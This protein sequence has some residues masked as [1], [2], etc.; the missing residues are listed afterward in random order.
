MKIIEVRTE[1]ELASLRTTWQELLSRSASDTIFLTWEWVSTWWSAYGIPGEF[2]VMLAV[3]DRNVTR[4]IAPLRRHEVSRYGRKFRVLSF[5]GDG[6]CDSDYLDFIIGLGDE[7]EVMNAFCKAFEAE[8]ERGT[9]LELN[10]IPEASSNLPILEV[11]GRRREMLW[12]EVDVPC[13]TVALP[14]NWEDFLKKLAPRFR[15][16]VRSVFRNLNGRAEVRFGFCQDPAEL[17]QLLPSLFEL[18]RLRWAKESQP[19]VFQ[20]DRKR[21]FYQKLSPLLLEGGHLFFSWLQWKGRTLACQYGFTYRNRYFHLQEGYDPA[22]EHWNVGIGLR[23][24][25]FQELF[26]RGITEY[27]FLAGVGR[28][29]SDWGAET[30][31]S[32]RVVLGHRQASHALF[33]RGPEWERQARE[34]LRQWI[35]SRLVAARQARYEERRRAAFQDQSAVLSGN[36][37]WMRSALASCY[38]RSPLPLLLPRFRNRYILRVSPNGKLPAIRFEKRRQPSVRILYYHRVNDEAD[39]FGGAIST[40]IFEDQM[41][42]VARHYRVVSLAEATRRLSDGA[43]AEPVVAI[44]F[45]DGY[46]DNYLNAFPILKRYGLLATIFLT[47]GSIDSRD[48]LWF[49]KLAL[50]VKK[51][52]RQFIDLEVDLPRRIWMRNETERLNAKSQLNAILRNLSDAER[53]RLLEEILRELDVPDDREDTML[54]WDQIRFMKQHRIDFGGHT[55]THPFVSRLG[56]EQALFEVSECKRRIEEELQAPVE[57]FAYP[58]GREGDFEAWNKEVLKK[59][60]YHSAVSTLW[61]VNYPSTDPMELRRGQPWEE[62]LAVFAAK[63]D[64]YQWRDV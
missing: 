31:L 16:K 32:K 60:G 19:G 26:K 14:A 57:H 11:L 2:N 20:W 23:A 1:A 22:C 21:L 30:K 41:G 58:N 38:F 25:S 59:A 56:P 45:D 12:S 29:K 52:S 33:C 51:T 62:D 61:G 24:W 39:P 63:L 44:T 9:V 18:H 3:D 48:R 53:R 55:V 42:F 15:T 50:A 47:T 36:G 5:I 8:L 40:R 46:Q 17:D 13:A 49:E 6:S 7:T 43:P 35:P 27:D 34:S 28:H 37:N 54:T 4:G 64:W 10:E